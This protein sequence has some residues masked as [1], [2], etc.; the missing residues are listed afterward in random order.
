M[1]KSSSNVIGIY[2]HIPCITKQNVP[3]FFLLEP[4]FF[5]NIFITTYFAVCSFSNYTFGKKNGKKNL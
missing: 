4:A 1:S 2:D 5:N 3:S